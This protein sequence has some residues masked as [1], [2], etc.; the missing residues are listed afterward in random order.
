MAT[1][2]LWT[3]LNLCE[4]YGEEPQTFSQKTVH[5][6]MEE[7]RN[8]EAA[9]PAP[10][11]EAAVQEIMDFARQWRDTYKDDFEFERFL[12]ERL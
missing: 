12:R 10:A 5:A 2:N 6:A 9:Q 7:L 4:I 11:T 8:I 3:I 1:S